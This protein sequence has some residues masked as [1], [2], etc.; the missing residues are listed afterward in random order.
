MVVDPSDTCSDPMVLTGSHN[1]T[2]SANISNDENTLIIHNDTIA[3][4]YYQAIAED[5]YII[6]GSALKKETTGCVTGIS[7]IAKPSDLKVYPTPTSDYLNI[8]VKGYIPEKISLYD[9]TGR[10]VLT[11]VPTMQFTSIPV[12]GFPNGIYLLKIVTANGSTEVRKVE[13]I[14]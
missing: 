9:L 3:N 10:E 4:L 1:W 14:K 11:T 13:I 8:K 12:D 2:N 5:F 6:N 7:A